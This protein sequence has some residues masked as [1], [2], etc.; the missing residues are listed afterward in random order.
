MLTVPRS[1]VVPVIMAVGAVAVLVA[2]HSLLF[3]S[4]FCS[5]YDAYILGNGAASVPAFVFYR[6]FYGIGPVIAAVALGVGVWFGVRVQVPAAQLAWYASVSGVL[7][8]AWFVFTLVVERILFFEYA[9][10]A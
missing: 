7:V 2:A 4:D 8:F 3:A 5:F 1:L 10:P 6:R 9:M